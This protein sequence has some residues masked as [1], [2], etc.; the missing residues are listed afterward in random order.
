MRLVSSL[1]LSTAFLMASCASLVHGTHQ[2]VPVTTT[3][4]G[5][6]IQ[7]GGE[8]YVSPADVSL[9]RNRDYQIVVSK[10]GYVTQTMEMHSSMSGAAFLDLIFII[11]WA[12]DL[13]DG[14]AWTLSPDT[15]Q[16]Q[17]EPVAVA[18][19]LHQDLASPESL[20]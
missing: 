17:L 18:S 2:T 10:S 4:T 13:A 8:S 6:T 20:K 5:A 16:V 11:P 12:V 14:A 7:V 19:S 3:P 15:V 1:A 9:S